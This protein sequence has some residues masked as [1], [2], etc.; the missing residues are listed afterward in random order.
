MPTSGILGGAEAA[1]GAVVAA[2][3]CG[4]ERPQPVTAEMAAT[5]NATSGM[6][7]KRLFMT[8]SPDGRQIGFYPPFVD[9]S[10]H[11][12]RAASIVAMSIFCMV[13]IASI[14]RFA[15]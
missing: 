14:A 2:G 4:S 15:A 3:G 5:A 7:E 6:R 12:R 13:I 8:R 1:A 9:S 11:P 10:R